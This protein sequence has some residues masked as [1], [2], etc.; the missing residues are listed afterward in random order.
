MLQSGLVWELRTSQ[1]AVPQLWLP[2]DVAGTPRHAALTLQGTSQGG[3]P[4][5]SLQLDVGPSSW[6]A[7]GRVGLWDWR[8][9]R[10]LWSK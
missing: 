4:R 6:A 2:L 5:F 3:Q 8:S 7:P 10:T 1:E 9:R